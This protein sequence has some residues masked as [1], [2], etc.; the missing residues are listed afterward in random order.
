MAIPQTTTE[1]LDI[2]YP[3]LTLYVLWGCIFGCTF[4][5]KISQ[6]I[7]FP[8][9]FVGDG[10]EPLDRV[11]ELA[12]GQLAV[13]EVVEDAA[14]R[15]HVRLLADLDPGLVVVPVLATAAL[16]PVLDRLG[17]HVA[18][19]AHPSV[20]DDACLVALQL[21]GDAE[22]DQLQLPLHDEEVGRLQI[23]GGN[24]INRL[25]PCFGPLLRPLSGPFFGLLY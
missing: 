19:R 10:Q 5:C 1:N 8:E 14:E 18:E 9:V 4:T 24:S 3:N 13:G 2:G 15:P 25:W 21:A 16:P 17:G 20:L 23:L 6:L 12:E 7:W 11:P 22:V